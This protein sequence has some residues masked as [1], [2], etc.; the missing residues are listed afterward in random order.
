MNPIRKK[1]NVRQCGKRKLRTLS[2]PGDGHCFY[3]S[4]AVLRRRLGPGYDDEEEA[5]KSMRNRVH[6]VASENFLNFYGAMLYHA[7]E[8]KMEGDET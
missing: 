3:R 7:S 8:L 1:I 2:I 4:V 5:I 6:E